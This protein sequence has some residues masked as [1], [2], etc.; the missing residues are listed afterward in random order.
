M[1]G[2]GTDRQT[3]RRTEI[4][5]RHSKGILFLRGLN[6]RFEILRKKKSKNHTKNHILCVNHEAKTVKEV[7]MNKLWV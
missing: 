3:K 4:A 7:K 2:Q 1:K 6:F 5:T